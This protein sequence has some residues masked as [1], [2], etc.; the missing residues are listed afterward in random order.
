MKPTFFAAA[1]DFRDWLERHHA[2]RRELLVGYYTTGSGRPSMTWTES[3]E[4]ALCFGWIDG[5]RKG[6][7]D[8]SYQ[9]RF[10]PRKPGGVWSAA[11]VRKAAELIAEGRMRPAGHAAFGTRR[12]DRTAVYSYEQREAPILDEPSDRELRSHPA[13]WEFLQSCAPS[14]RRAAVHWVMSAKQE[15]TRGRRLA[16]LIEDSAQGRTVRPLTPRRRG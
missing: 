5:V 15:S 2:D 10:T 12:P 8:E 1:A 16:T 4:E 11:N 13:A 6:L 7:D 3:V 9:I 14:Y